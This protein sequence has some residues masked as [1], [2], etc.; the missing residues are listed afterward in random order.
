MKI[1][2]KYIVWIIVL[3]V[4][5]AAAYQGLVYWSHYKL[6]GVVFFGGVQT[7]NTEIVKY[8]IAGHRFSIPINYLR[9]ATGKRKALKPR[10]LVKTTQLSLRVVLPDMKPYSEE[11]RAE[12]ERLGWGNK[13]SLMLM[14]R[15]RDPSVLT[16]PFTSASGKRI[17]PVSGHRTVAEVYEYRLASLKDRGLSIEDRIDPNGPPDLLHYPDQYPKGYDYYARLKDG[18]AVYQA[19]CSKAGSAPSPD[20]GTFLDYAEDLVV[21]YTFSRDYLMEWESV[22]QRIRD[23]VRSLEV[24]VAENLK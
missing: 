13:V 15:K 5:L 12:F 16:Q 23:L 21:S 1:T 11:T 8:Q 7:M 2:R 17:Q 9:K 10:K 14:D 19:I 4:V 20:C 18:Q 6:R 22:E 24:P 3:L